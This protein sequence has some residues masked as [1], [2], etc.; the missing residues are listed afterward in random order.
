M[1]VDTHIYRVSKRLELVEKRMNA[2]HAHYHLESL[3]P[4]EERFLF[5]MLLITHGR[6]ALARPSARVVRSALSP[7]FAPPLPGLVN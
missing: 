6:K 4:A 1:P 2:E 7:V 3:V 5:H